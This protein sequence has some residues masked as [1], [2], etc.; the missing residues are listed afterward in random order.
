MKWKIITG[1]SVDNSLIQDFNENLKI[2]NNPLPFKFVITTIIIK[3]ILN[4]KQNRHFII[5]PG[6]IYERY[7]PENIQDI[8]KPHP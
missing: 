4:T 2:L 5:T 8:L 3:P 7:A 1:I 6:V